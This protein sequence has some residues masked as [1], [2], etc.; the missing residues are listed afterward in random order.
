MK[1][2]NEV[3]PELVVA[4]L[5]ASLWFAPKDLS[6]G[7]VAVGKLLRAV[8][9]STSAVLFGKAYLLLLLNEEKFRTNQEKQ[10]IDESVD[11]ELYTYRK[12]AELDK[13]KLQIKHEVM[14]V[15]APHFQQ[16]YQLELESSPKPDEHP[17]LTE[18]QKQSAAKNAI[19]QALAPTIIQPKFSEEELRK[20]FPESMD[21]T[22]WKGCLKAL[23]AGY[24][25][26][27][28]VNDVLSCKS[29]KELGLAYF[30]FLKQRYL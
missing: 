5:V 8:G 24:S 21:L 23:Q 2:P 9:Y 7:N 29:N 4:T 17:E 1:R 25:K 18:E 28:V 19:E 13:A 15:A 12:G 30:E 27:E 16:M 26:D 3:L 20:H 22:T 6:L 10:L 11:L 14:Q